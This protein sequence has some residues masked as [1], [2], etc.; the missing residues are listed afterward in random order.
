[1]HIAHF[2]LTLKTFSFTSNITM[3]K[4]IEI[5]SDLESISILGFHEKIYAIQSKY[6][7]NTGKSLGPL[8]PKA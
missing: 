5:R 3:G 6:D 8:M 7:L 1:M 2:I 4:R